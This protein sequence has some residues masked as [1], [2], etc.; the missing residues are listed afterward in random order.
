M[1]IKERMMALPLD[2]AV[3]IA[4]SREELA[5]RNAGHKNRGEGA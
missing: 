4:A 2:N 1:K 5:A 3:E